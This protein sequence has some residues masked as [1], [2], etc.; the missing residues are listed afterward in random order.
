MPTT[1]FLPWPLHC[2]LPVAVLL[3]LAGCMGRWEL[4]D[5]G[6]LLPYPRAAPQARSGCVDGA[7]PPCGERPHDAG[8]LTPGGS[9]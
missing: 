5:M 1:R 9:R 8:T 3:V 4:G 2:L 7:Q 6:G